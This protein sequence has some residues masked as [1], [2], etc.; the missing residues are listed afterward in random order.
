M[1]AKI[2][3]E[4]IRKKAEIFRCIHH[5][6]HPLL[7]IESDVII[8]TTCCDK[9]HDHIQGFIER[10]IENASNEE[11]EEPPSAPID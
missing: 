2:D 7:K 4:H 10:Q 8:I 9:F 11:S 3:L 6:K 5:K 1:A